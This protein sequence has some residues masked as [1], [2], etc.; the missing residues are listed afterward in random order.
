MNNLFADLPQTLETEQFVD[1]LKRDN[2]RIERILSQGH[3]SPERGWY[4]Q[5]EHEW[6]LVLEGEGRL[7][8]ED[9]REV[10]LTK[11]DHINIPAHCR[12]KVIWTDP[13]QITVWLAVFYR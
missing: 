5:D 10:S 7:A 4:D 9:G 1:L 12:H 8:F 3:R 11:G 6:V 13:D 2:L